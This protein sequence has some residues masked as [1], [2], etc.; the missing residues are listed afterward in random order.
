[1]VTVRTPMVFLVALLACSPSLAQKLGTSPCTT[2]A[3]AET[4]R[5]REYVDRDHHFCFRYPR[6]YTPI[7]HPKPNCRGPKLEDITTGATIGV[8]AD[9]QNFELSNFVRNAPTGIDSPPE[10]V[11][12]GKNTFYY[13]GPGG[14]GVSYP[15]VYFFNLR[16]K[17]LA[18][19]FDGPY[20]HDKTPTRATKKME[21]KLLTTF[22]EF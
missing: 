12:I 2:A 5:W 14:G 20:V 3:Q 8:C 4:T 22:R 11:R 10:P 13:Y 7:S 18:I 21:R 6:S 9:D 17:V 16:G 1:M 15:D 19:N